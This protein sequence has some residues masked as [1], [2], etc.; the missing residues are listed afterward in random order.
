MR[1]QGAAKAPICPI[2][3]Y[4]VRASPRHLDRF[5]QRKH[6]GPPFPEWLYKALIY[7]IVL[8]QENA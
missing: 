8:R 3:N 7:E 4:P 6:G 1:S 2:K 5:R